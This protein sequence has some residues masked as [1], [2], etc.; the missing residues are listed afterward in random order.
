MIS[1][2]EF[3]KLE[4]RVGIVL[5]CERVPGADKLLKLRVKVGEE[6]RTIAT[7]IGPS[8]SPEELVGKKIIVLVNLEPR[9]IRGIESQGMLLAA[10]ET[11]ENVAV[12]TVD[13]EMEAGTRVY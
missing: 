8:Y 5:E 10:G 9:K 1:Y 6:E 11:A 4:M 7:G 13:K 12:L 3:A 2:D